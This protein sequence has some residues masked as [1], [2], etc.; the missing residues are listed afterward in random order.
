MARQISLTARKEWVE[1]LRLRDRSAAFGVIKTKVLQASA[2]T[3]DRLLAATR[4]PIDGQRRRRK[5]VG[6]AVRR[7]IPVGTFA[8]WRNPPPGYF[9]V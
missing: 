9:V 5:G 7:S 4:A 1:A 8:D 6:S 2:A 3:I